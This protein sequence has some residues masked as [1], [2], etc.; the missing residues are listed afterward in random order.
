MPEEEQREDAFGQQLNELSNHMDIEE[1][2]AEGLWTGIHDQLPQRKRP[3]YWYAAAAAI[4][5]LVAV[6]I[7]LQ[8]GG[9]PK[10]PGTTYAQ[11]E[12]I[13]DISVELASIE[14]DYENQVAEKLR[15][16][17][18]SDIDSAELRFIYDELDLLNQLN[19]EYEQELKEMG[20]N[21]KIIQ[22]ILK[23]YERRLQLL[24]R[25]MQESEKKKKEHR[26]EDHE[27]IL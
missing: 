12:S 17:E 18:Q 15:E 26:H 19:T 1:I 27:T 10:D 25:L 9:G 7:L 4:I 16:I 20:A 5:A 13:S 11:I 2:D 24:D 14:S 21:E 23:C 8:M 3:R 22:T 6:G